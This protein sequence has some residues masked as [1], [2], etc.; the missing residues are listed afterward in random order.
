MILP[1]KRI[2]EDH[3]LLGLGA[4]ILQ[5]LNQETTVSNLWDQLKKQRSKGRRAIPVT[6]E[7]FAL[8]L[9]L[10]YV[11]GALE[12]KAGLVRRVLR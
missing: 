12:L 5:L 2:R 8:A 3:S 4:D 9:D 7:W 11:T 10:L 1:T 6:F